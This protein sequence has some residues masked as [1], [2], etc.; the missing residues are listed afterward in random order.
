MKGTLSHIVVALLIGS[1]LVFS[2]PSYSAHRSPA[3][4]QYLVFQI[5][6]A[7][8]GFRTEKNRHAISHLPKKRYIEKTVQDIVDEIGTSDGTQHRLGFALGPLALDH[9]D[10]QLRTL[11]QW[12][13]EIARKKGVAV[14]LHI[15]D[16]K[17]WLN[18]DDLWRKP[19]NVEWLDWDRT[20]NSGQ[21]L[22]WGRA[23]KLAPQICFNSPAVMQEV[24]RIARDVIGT[25]IADELSTLSDHE[26]DQLFGGVI[27]GWE[28]GLGRDYDTRGS[29]GYCALTNRGFSRANPPEDP[30]KEL[31]SA[32]SAWI[33]LWTS[34]VA[35]GGVPRGKIYSHTTFQPQSDYLETKQSADRATR[36]PSS[37]SDYVGH[38]VPSIAFGNN[39]RPGFSTYPDAEFFQLIYKELAQHG[40]PPW[41]SAEG[42]NVMIHD[43][44]PRIPDES[45]ETYLARMF[46]HGAALVN[47]F[48]WGIPGDN[49]FRRSAESESSL[50]AYRKF[51]NGQPLQEAPLETS[52]MPSAEALPARI[53]AMHESVRRYQQRGGD[54]R[55][56]MRAM[57]EL[58]RAV[59]TGDHEK[60]ERALEDVLEIVE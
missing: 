18:R 29:L 31:Q 52:Y 34:S 28:T 17:F 16:S 47:I 35:A 42:A 10:E 53:H 33:E 4:V 41:A 24:R 44:P 39:H 40:S 14:V 37:Y 21:F 32:L 49:A 11:V 9:T 1:S 59:P 8:P 27:V 60:I 30:D 36:W 46:N 2:V 6:T 54:M 23:W 43:G 13:F 45:M 12:A 26:I 50:A 3:E 5:F 15:D 7:G 25:A 56:V 48:G 20:P 57:E 51:L 55:K 38:A 19:D 58:Q 22:N